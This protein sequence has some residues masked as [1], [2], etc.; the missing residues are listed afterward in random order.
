M[1]QSWSPESSPAFA[2]AGAELAAV[3]LQISVTLG[4]TVV[5]AWQY[6][7]Y[8]KSVF[9]WW[10]LAWGLYV[11]RLAAIGAF[12]FT[13]ETVLLYWHQ[14]FTGWT[15]IAVLATAMVFSGRLRRRRWHVLAV[16]FPPV[17]SYFAVYHLGTYTIASVPM[18][19]FLSC[20]TLWTGVVFMRYARMTHST[21]ASVLATAFFIWG[22]HHLDYPLL[23]AYGAWLPWGYYVDVLLTITVGA[24]ILLLVTDDLRRGVGTLGTLSSDL[25]SAASSSRDRVVATVLQRI[26]SVPAV[27]GA[28]VFRLDSRHDGYFERGVGACESWTGTS[29]IHSQAELLA[30]VATGVQRAFIA[31][32]WSAASDG[33][34][35]ADSPAF[36][37]AAVLPVEDQGTDGS[38]SALVIVAEDHVPFAALDAEF[39]TALGRQMGGTLENSRLYTALQQRTADLERLSTR[40]VL[41]QEEERRRLSRELHDETAQLLS[42]VKM[43]LAILREVVPEPHA[44]RVDDALALT[45]AGIRSIRAV[46]LDLRPTLLDDLGLIP[47]L[48]SVATAF[49]QRSGTQVRLDLMSPQDLPPLDDGADLAFYRA[50]QEALSNIGRHAGASVVDITLHSDNGNVTLTVIDDGCGI[51]KAERAAAGSGMGLIGMRERFASLGGSVR[52]RNTASGGAQLEVSLPLDIGVTA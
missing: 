23:R 52:L 44:V 47:A 43:E 13:R 16:L 24:G 9:A 37:F 22:I 36:P 34:G 1:L 12:I 51:P 8:R 49:A 50:L 6:R 32:E 25:M 27:R 48:R 35:D 41:Q 4:L 46:M 38:G 18:V 14:V 15:A 17:W 20:A 7:Q 26:V 39:L 45:D 31:P 30:R 42:A 28:A 21:G 10:T 19:L 29:P 40:M 5:C 33:D 11:V 3:L 2:A